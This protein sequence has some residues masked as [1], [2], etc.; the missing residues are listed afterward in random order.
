M[1]INPK[2]G[3]EDP[4]YKPTQTTDIR[5]NVDTSMPVGAK[6]LSANITPM[7][8]NIGGTAPVSAVQKDAFNTPQVE[9]VG[10]GP[11]VNLDVMNQYR[12]DL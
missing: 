3:L 9:V 12:K 6:S 8:A 1:A 11:K 5:G 10:G 4:N 2:T 7:N